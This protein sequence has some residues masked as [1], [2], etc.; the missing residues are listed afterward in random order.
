MDG[1]RGGERERERE[2]ESK[3]KLNFGVTIGRHIPHCG[4]EFFTTSK[5]VLSYI[6]HTSVLYIH[7]HVTTFIT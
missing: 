3:N 7:V 6:L 1:K 4:W 5:G 2:R